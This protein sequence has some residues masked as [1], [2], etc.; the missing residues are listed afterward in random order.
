LFIIGFIAYVAESKRAYL[1][2]LL[3]VWVLGALF[4]LFAS[5]AFHPDA[6]SY[7]FRS[8]DAKL[9]FSFE[10]AHVLFITLTNAGITIA[11]LAALAFYAA[12]RRVRYF[13]NTAPLIVAAIL[14]VLVTTG[15]PSQPRLWAMPFLLAFIGGVF[16]DILETRYRRGF[17]WITGALLLAQ[18]ALCLAG[19]PL[20]IQ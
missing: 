13:G 3:I 6:Y 18:V 5:Y 20:L 7:V 12:V 1:P 8:E 9:G 10:P 17:L 16:A 4:I 15:V 11:A 14:L 2:T 19:L